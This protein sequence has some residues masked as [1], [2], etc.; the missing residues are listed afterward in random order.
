MEKSLTFR[1]HL[2]T[3]CINLS[4][5]VTL[6]RRLISSEWG[7][8][9]TT[10]RTTALSLLYSAAEYCS[11]VWCYSAHTC[12]ID[13]VLNDALRIVTGCLSSTATDHLPIF[14]G[15]QPAEFRR[16]GAAPS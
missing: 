15:I 6:L 8:A 7:A 16:L 12:L 10:L 2:V 13:S 9:A 14:S 5:R 1:H 4:S 3:L 11:P